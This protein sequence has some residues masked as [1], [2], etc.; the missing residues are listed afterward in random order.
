M[1][2]AWM[3]V[4]LTAFPMVASV[5]FTVCATSLTST[6]AVE[7]CTD[8][9]KLMVAGWLTSSSACFDCLPKPAAVTVTV[10]RPGASWGNS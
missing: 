2:S 10:Y 3:V 4:P 9:V 7:L 8:S 5:V 1:G 6:T